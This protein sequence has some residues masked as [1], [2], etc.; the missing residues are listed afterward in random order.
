MQFDT[1]PGLT[2][3]HL[4]WFSGE[5]NGGFPNSDDVPP[6]LTVGAFGEELA[7]GFRGFAVGQSTGDSQLRMTS[8][9]RTKMIQVQNGWLVA[10]RTKKP[11]SGYQGFTGDKELFSHAL[12]GFRK[13]TDSRKLGTINPNLW[14]VTFIH[15]IPKLNV[16]GSIPVARFVCRRCHSMTPAAFR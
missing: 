3:G 10:N 5:M 16:A 9:D 2:N 14:E 15:H 8:V 4:G 1:L 11:G 12:E 7:F 13:F 6:I